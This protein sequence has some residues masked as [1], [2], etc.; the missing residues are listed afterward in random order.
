MHKTKLIL[1]VGA[2]AA[3]AATT[4]MGSATAF[5]GSSSTNT[6][7]AATYASSAS[8]APSGVQTAAKVFDQPNGK[9]LKKMCYVDLS[10]DYAAGGTIQSPQKMVKQMYGNKKCKKISVTISPTTGYVGQVPS[11]GW[12]S[13][14]SPPD[15]E[16]ATPYVYYNGGGTTLNVTF[17]KPV[18]KGGMEAEPNPFEEHTI[19]AHFG[20]SGG[21]DFDVSV[22]ANGSSGAKLLGAKSKDG[23]FDEI[24]VSSDI[25]FAVAQIRAC[26]SK[27]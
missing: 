4:M 24:D 23:K 14:G 26:V 17:S 7:T 3:V 25:D 21:A 6:G 15:T 10:D 9:Y 13:W 2:S 27:C 20:G 19:S 12:A 18:Q 22:V 5:A 16:S 11:G 8:V 1:A